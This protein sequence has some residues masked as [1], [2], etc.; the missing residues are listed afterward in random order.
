MYALVLDICVMAILIIFA[1]IGYKNGIFK[2]FLSFISTMFSGI[3]S[4]YISG[5]LSKSIYTGI[6]GPQIQSK[7]ELSSAKSFSSADQ[8]FNLF[9]PWF[10]KL[11]RELRITPEEI[12]HIIVSSNLDP[13]PRKIS[14]LLYPLITNVL[15][16]VLIPVMFILL[17]LIANIFFRCVSKLFGMNSLKSTDS[18]AGMAFGALKGYIVLTVL[19]CC[20][21]IFVSIDNNLP[22]IFSS[23]NI[24]STV[25]FKEIYNNNFIYSFYKK[26]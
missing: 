26:I 18:F 6:I 24:S 1:F 25:I 17:V 2:S 4:V 3:F 5:A 8:I 10:T 7:I 15:R 21:R 13:T 11:L 9:S 23:S 22:E 16:S 20:L 14:E 19:I 12:N